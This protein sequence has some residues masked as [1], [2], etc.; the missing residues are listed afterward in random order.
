[1]GESRVRMVGEEKWR[2]PTEEGETSFR[3][4]EKEMEEQEIVCGEHFEYN[5]LP[6]EIEEDTGRVPWWEGKKEEEVEERMRKT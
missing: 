6:D 2:V 1:M 3:E 5:H 4:H